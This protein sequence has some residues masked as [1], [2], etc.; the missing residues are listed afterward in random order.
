MGH[1]TKMGGLAGGSC[2]WA[3]AERARG[4]NGWVSLGVELMGA[5]WGTWRQHIDVSTLSAPWFTLALVK[6]SMACEMTSIVWG[7]LSTVTA[8]RLLVVG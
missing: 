2:R 4:H 5:R 1:G 8:M 6:A 7:P 3:G